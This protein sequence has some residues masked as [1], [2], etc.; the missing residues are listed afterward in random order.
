M[1][2]G[3]SDTNTS[4]L[5]KYLHQCAHH[6][7][8]PHS[9]IHFKTLIISSLINFITKHKNHYRS[10]QDP[11]TTRPN[12]PETQRHDTGAFRM[13]HGDASITHNRKRQNQ[14]M[15]KCSN[16]QVTMEMD[17]NNKVTLRQSGLHSKRQSN[18]QE[19]HGKEILT[20]RVVMKRK[21]KQSLQC[22]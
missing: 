10:V 9:A 3:K 22:V 2:T 4:T 7:H 12:Q 1:P 8:S 18:H 20:K 5:K 11:Q 13:Q 15:P 17:K 21:N 16:V 6:H 14:V 19:T